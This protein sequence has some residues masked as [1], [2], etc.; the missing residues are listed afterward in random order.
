MMLR[1]LTEDMYS[2]ESRRMQ[3]WYARSSTE[4]PKLWEAQLCMGDLSWVTLS[5]SLSPLL[6]FLIPFLSSAAA[7]QWVTQ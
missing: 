4:P 5:T 2:T 7:L 1:P 6:V 3:E